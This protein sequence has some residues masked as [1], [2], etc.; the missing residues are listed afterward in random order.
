MTTQ[1]ERDGS[2]K[3]RGSNLGARLDA[4]VLAPSEAQHLADSSDLDSRVQIEFRHALDHT[5]HTA[6]A[7]RQWIE[8]HA[9]FGDAYAVLPVLATQRVHRTTQL[10]KEVSL[11]L[12]NMDVT[13][14]TEGLQDL[15]EAIG[16][17]HRQLEVLCKQ[18]KQSK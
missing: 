9:E 2:E 4:M 18:A 13:M 12:Q 16:Q 8:T 6:T 5:R 15:Y 3:R 10:A 7:V 14:E 1:E 11:D 17:L